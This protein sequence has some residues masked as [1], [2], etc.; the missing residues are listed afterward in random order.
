MQKIGSFFRNTDGFGDE[1]KARFQA[2]GATMSAAREPAVSPV[3]GSL[4]SHRRSDWLVMEL[5]PLKQIRR[6]TEATLNDVVLAVVTGAFRYF[7]EGRGADPDATPLKTSVPVNVRADDDRS[8]GNKISNWMF[9][10]PVHEPDP[11]R[12]LHRVGELTRELKESNQA[13]GT[14]LMMQFAEFAP[15]SLLSLAARASDGAV[16]TFVTN[17][18]G[19]QFPL[20]M[21]G[22]KMIHM[23]PQ[24]PLIAGMGIAVGLMS[25]NGTICWGVTSDAEVVPDIEDFTAAIET[26]FTDLIEATE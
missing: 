11:V 13:L 20:Y 19:P 12:R 6:E 3:A 9:N 23:L 18:P 5:E 21:F 26:S 7:F 22:A 4:T 16:D 14:H 8:L 10:L 1:L 2:L 25:Y 15:T 17:V 24:V